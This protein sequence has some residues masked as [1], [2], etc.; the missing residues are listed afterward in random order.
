MRNGFVAIAALCA[1]AMGGCTI[2]DEGATDYRRVDVEPF[3]KVVAG[4]ADPTSLAEVP[5]VGKFD[6]LGPEARSSAIADG[7]YYQISLKGGVIKDFWDFPGNLFDGT[8]VQDTGEIAIVAKVYEFDQT[9]N[10]IDFG[11]ANVKQAR[12]IY[13]SDDVMESQFLN[14]AQMPIYGP[15][16]YKRNR[17][18]VQIV[19]LEL[20]QMSARTKALL[21]TLANIGKTAATVYASPA[22]GAASG[23]VTDLALAFLN[24]EQD[25]VIF[26]YYL[27]FAPHPP[28]KFVPQDYLSEG[29]RVFLRKQ[30]RTTDAEWSRFKLDQLTG[31]LKLDG[32]NFRDD[33]YLVMDVARTDADLAAIE[34]Q[35]LDALTQAIR[36]FGALDPSVTQALA[37]EAERFMTGKATAEQ[38][39][40]QLNLIYNNSQA[41][42]LRAFELKALFDRIAESKDKMVKN[43]EPPLPEYRIDTILREMRRK[44]AR[45][46][47]TF[48]L[49]QLTFDEIAKADRGKLTTDVLEV[50]KKGA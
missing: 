29:E 36:E 5:F 37:K 8:I 26:N 47:P 41:D 22:G 40:R 48:D 43:E 1:L 13:Y 44:I 34:G 19:G 3:A 49:N 18:F 21:E 32:K 15:V 38:T 24:G 42:N 25:D 4:A 31:E 33:T 7:D 2:V 30:D 12:V 28:S 6:P 45:I 10:S 14:F 9:N 17:V 35:K 23:V 50:L 16:E 20:D 27:T 39:G 11:P 46:D